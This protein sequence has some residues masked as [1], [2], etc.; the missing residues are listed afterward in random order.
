MTV[1]LSPEPVTSAR[2]GSVRIEQ[3]P[4]LSLF[5]IHSLCYISLSLKREFS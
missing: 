3:G 2:K 4:E 1:F 5:V